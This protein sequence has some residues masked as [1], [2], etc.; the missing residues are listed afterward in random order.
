ME[1]KIIYTKHFWE[2]FKERF[3]WLIDWD[4]KILEVNSLLENCQLDKSYLNTS[5]YL[6]LQEQYGYNRK[7]EFWID[8][9]NK[10]VFVSII[11]KN[12]KIILTCYPLTD[13]CFISRKKFNKNTKGKQK[14]GSYGKKY[15]RQTFSELDAMSF[16]KDNT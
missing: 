12:H 14:R 10:I 15:K 7:Y 9:V 8:K 1:K 5:F 4:K 6:K 16:Y 3:D 13:N 11:K 2:R